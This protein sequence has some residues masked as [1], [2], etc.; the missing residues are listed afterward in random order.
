VRKLRTRN[1]RNDTTYFRYFIKRFEILLWRLFKNAQL[2][3]A[4]N[5]EERGVLLYVAVTKDKHNSADGYF[6]TVF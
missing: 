3:G 6:S 1:A 5:H 4:R 2:Q